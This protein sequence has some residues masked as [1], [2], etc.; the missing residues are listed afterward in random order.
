MLGATREGTQKFLR[1]A[2]SIDLGIHKRMDQNQLA[3]VE[4]LCQALY[5]GLQ[6]L[7]ERSSTAIADLQSTA[8][9]IP[10]CQ[11]ILDNSSNP[12]A[13]LLQVQVWKIL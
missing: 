5:Q 11:F 4:K 7:K 1:L 3:Q 13:Q 6:V 8:D 12:Y 10:Q 2:A 9:F